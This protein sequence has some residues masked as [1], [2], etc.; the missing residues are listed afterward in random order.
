MKVKPKIALVVTTLNEE[1]NIGDFLTSVKKQSLSPDEFVV[2]DGGS[3][4]KTVEKLKTSGLDIKIYIEPGANRAVGRNSGVKKTKS[5]IIAFADAGCIL[6]KTWLRQI[7]KPFVDPEV[8]VVAG[9]YRA[10]TKNVF[11]K[12]V[13]PFAL[14]M[15]DKINPKKF[16]PASRSM[17]IRKKT[18]KETKGFPE[19]GPDNE[20]YVFARRLKKMRVK[21]TF[22]EKAVVS[23]LPRD[24]LQSFFV[25]I[26][27]FARGDA[28]FGFRILKVT[29]IFLRYLFFLS[30]LM[31]SVAFSEFTWYFLGFFLVYLLWA[32]LKNY[33]YV[34]DWQAFF[35]LPIL[36]VTSDLA[37]MM[38]TIK[39]VLGK[40]NLEER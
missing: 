17:A 10:K 14:V 15:P 35:W 7:T 5:E 11:E 9:Y 6:E 8:A 28:A 16:L 1:K 26:Y 31:I 18:F 29:T 38:G 30:L 3:I 23:W 22:N 19:N 24:N 4:D 27:R 25:M 20:D 33:R 13:T 39:G 21:I 12:C 36:Q 32:V 40:L 37:V 34:K 2:V